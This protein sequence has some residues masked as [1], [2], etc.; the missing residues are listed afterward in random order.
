MPFRIVKQGDVA[1]TDTGQGE[2]SSRHPALDVYRSSR[3]SSSLLWLA[4]FVSLLSAACARA[5]STPENHAKIQLISEEKSIRHAR[6]L[7]VGLLFELDPGWH[8]YWQNPGDSGEPPKIQWQLPH[9]F[10]AGVIRWPRPIRLGTPSVRNYG[11]EGQVLLMTTIQP[12]ANFTAASPV[13]ITANVQYIVCRE[14]CIPGKLAVTLSLP[15]NARSIVEQSQW[16]NIF[17]ATKAQLPKPLPSSWKASARSV[18]DHFVLS[19]DGAGSDHELMFFPLDRSVIENGPPQSLAADS[20]SLRLTLKK[21]EQLAMPV[22]TL[23]GVLVL[24]LNLA[25]EIAAPVSSS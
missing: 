22:S 3:R 17:E 6:L 4:V 14:I 7:W 24:D 20:N 11:Y 8:I 23:R 1:T 10:R 15:L 5:Q 19:L 18:G 9:G 12:P 16:R 2:R 21:S 25:Y 13:P